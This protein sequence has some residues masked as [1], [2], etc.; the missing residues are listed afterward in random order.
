MATTT[1]QQTTATAQAFEALGKSLTLA[2]CNLTKVV[3]Q[4]AALLVLMICK[5][6]QWL[7]TSHTVGDDS[8]AV[9]LTGWQYLGLGVIS[10]AAGFI[11]SIEW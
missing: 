2:A 10:F 7:N 3:Y 4:L 9:T 5:V 8:E 11:L 1:I 6:W